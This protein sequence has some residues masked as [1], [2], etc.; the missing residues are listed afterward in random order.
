MSELF[1]GTISPED[2]DF[3][4]FYDGS[5]KLIPGN[6]ELEVVVTDAFIGME[7]GSALQ[8]C[9]IFVAISTPGE[10]LGQ[11]YKYNAKVF[12]MDASKRDRAMK[13]LQL[14]DTQAGSPLSSGRLPMTTENLQEHW[15]GKAYARAK[16]GVID[17]TDKQT[18]EVTGQTNFIRGFGWQRD[19]LPKSVQGQQAAVQGQQQAQTS[20]PA[21]QPEDNGDI[22]F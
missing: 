7:E 22:D 8:V 11:K 10:F 5:Q 4:G 12:D 16:I 18:G 21:D 9:K 14:L 3:D 2:I 13:N 20:A 19:R 15:T 17:I 1:L 6:T